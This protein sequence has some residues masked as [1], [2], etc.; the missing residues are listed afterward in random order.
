M[1]LRVIKW[2]HLN[3]PLPLLRQEGGF[4]KHPLARAGKEVL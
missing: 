4:D 1:G 2:V 3:S